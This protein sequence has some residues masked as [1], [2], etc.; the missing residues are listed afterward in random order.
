LNKFDI[1][2]STIN[3]LKPLIALHMA[4]LSYPMD[5][6]LEDR[7]LE[8]DIYELK[9]D[10]R[11]IGYAGLF[12]ETV[13]FFY[14]KKEYFRYAPEALSQFIEEKAL[15]RVFIMT[16]D[17]LL[18]GLIAEWDHDIERQ[19][20]WFSDGGYPVEP[21]PIMCQAVFRTASAKDI[22]LIRQ[23]AGDFFEEASGGF[24]CLEDRV[25]AETI[26]ILEQQD[27]LI[28]FGIIETSQFC[29]DYVSIG[30]FVNPKHRKKRGART[31]LL[32]LKEIA[33]KM[34]LKPV[35]GC[36]YYNTLSRKSL[37]SAGMIATS[38]GYEAVL[39]GKEKLPL[40]TGNPPGELV[41]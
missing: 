34:N 21:D 13:Q 20:C 25:T 1:L 2:Q 16:Q 10:S 29:T 37:E 38:I 27:A 4:G 14:V 15:E 17:T 40:R 31:I 23:V 30:M 8:S 19:A 35:A 39:K 36:W 22:E 11:T 9:L 7:L 41:D 6:W 26:F 18:D 3:D 12:Q 24:D 28:G 5:S 33:Y 32:N